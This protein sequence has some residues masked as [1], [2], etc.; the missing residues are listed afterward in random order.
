MDISVGRL[1]H[2]MALQVPSELPLGLV[3]ITGRVEHL[4]PPAETH[5][6]GEVEKKQVCFELVDG[7][8]RLPCRVPGQ[9][10]TETQVESGDRIR[11][12]G[13][14]LFDPRSVHYY[15]LARDLEVLAATPAEHN[16]A[17][18]AMP[19]AVQ[20]R[21]E[22]A[23][24]VQGELPAWV[25]QLAPPE[26]QEELGLE[27]EPAEREAREIPEDIP[28][29]A[30]EVEAPAGE[31]PSGMLAFLS[32]AIDSDEDI[33][34]TREM[35]DEYLHETEEERSETEDRSTEAPSGPAAAEETNTDASPYAE[36]YAQDEDALEKPVL[37]VAHEPVAE[38]QGPPGSRWLLFFILFLVLLILILLLLFI[39]WN[40][41]QVRIASTSLPL[42]V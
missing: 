3:F 14:L 8:H 13:H 41:L 22:A 28:P 15:L 30:I 26:I 11:V 7:Q 17:P 25:K 37:V 6:A 36:P 16:P 18:I 38:S 34:L 1:N 5:R 10:V 27:G 19:A 21:A 12:S 23:S 33:E 42:R 2:R 4:S 40:P 24:L 20:Q 29:P 32:S 39:L 31:L 9:V 35:I